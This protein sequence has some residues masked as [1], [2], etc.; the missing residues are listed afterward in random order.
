MYNVAF[1]KVVALQDSLE[2]QLKLCFWMDAT[3]IV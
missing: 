3:R 2:P 1:H